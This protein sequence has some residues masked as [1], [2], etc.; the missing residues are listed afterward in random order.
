MTASAGVH[1]VRLDATQ[2][3][4]QTEGGGARSCRYL[5]L[6]KYIRLDTATQKIRK[7][8]NFLVWYV[9]KK[10][11]F[12]FDMLEK[13]KINVW[14]NNNRERG[15]P[16]KFEILLWHG[17]NLKKNKTKKMAYIDFYKILLLCFIMII[18]L[19]REVIDYEKNNW[20]FKIYD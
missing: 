1:K 3:I 2:R 20:F 14:L 8:E 18:M 13:R 4:N 12:W 10:K 16:P 17:F 11:I 5:Y 15:V 19:L 7:K 6:Y 9:G